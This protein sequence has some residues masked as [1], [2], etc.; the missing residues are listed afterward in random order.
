M[1]SKQEATF[2]ALLCN[3]EGENS[4][5]SELTPNEKG[6][7][8]ERSRV[9]SLESVLIHLKNILLCCGSYNIYSNMT[10]TFSPLSV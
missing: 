6:G 2:F 7:Q 9:A 5:L 10:L 3:Y 8:N 4:F 1:E